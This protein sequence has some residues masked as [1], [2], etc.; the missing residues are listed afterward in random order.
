MRA[1]RAAWA[2][3]DKPA[4]TPSVMP[5]LLFRL[6]GGTHDQYTAFHPFAV[7]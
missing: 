3:S 6:K 7:A 4:G 1:A 5:D 2:K